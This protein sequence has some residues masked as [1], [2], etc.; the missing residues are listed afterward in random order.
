[1]EYKVMIKLYVPEIEQEFDMYI[2]VNKSV[3][4]VLTLLVKAVNSESFDIFPIKN[5]IRLINKRTSQV[6]EHTLVIRQTD[7]KN[8]TEL[9]II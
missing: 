8:G 9:V 7:I 1:M 5:N 4:Q 2:P 6:Y 3:G